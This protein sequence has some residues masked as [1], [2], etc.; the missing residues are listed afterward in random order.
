[1]Y[2]L[3]SRIEVYA[4]Y[5]FEYIKY[6]EFRA[7]TNAILYIVTRKSFAKGNNIRTR[8]GYFKTRPKSLD[9]QYVN[10][11]YELEIKRFIEKEEF[12]VFLDIGACLGEYCIWLG[13]KGKKC[14]AFEPV[15]YSYEMIEKNIELNN[16]QE[17]VKVYNYGL[18]MEYSVEYFKMDETNPGSNRK[19][20]EP[21]DKTEKFEIYSLD[22]K[23]ETLGL[24]PTN[25]ILIKIDIEG[26]ELEMLNG[27]QKF[28]NEFKNIVL[29]VEEK[30]SGES[31]I[32]NKLTHIAPFEFGKIDQYN[33]F[34]RKAN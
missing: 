29:I 25:R 24:L 19:V 15:I 32:R 8:M 17:K 11:A 4:L 22:E 6:G 7:I 3:I 26:M 31:N 2:N 20:A 1:M 16:L 9:F 34:A 27:A 10:Y 28:L 33:I 21:G 18:G 30:F 23:Y 5:L 14:I 13:R 12:D